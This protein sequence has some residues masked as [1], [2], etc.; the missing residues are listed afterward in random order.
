MKNI[1]T[2]EIKREHCIRSQ[3]E[4]ERKRKKRGTDTGKQREIFK[5]VYAEYIYITNFQ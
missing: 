1:E 3:R 5:N 4:Y 2:N